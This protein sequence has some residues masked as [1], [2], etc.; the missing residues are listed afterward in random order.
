MKGK[1]SKKDMKKLGKSFPKRVVSLLLCFVLVALMFPA[2]ELHAHAGGWSEY[3]YDGYPYYVEWDDE[4]GKGTAYMEC[5]YC[6]HVME[7]TFSDNEHDDAAQMI[8]DA[9]WP[10]DCNHCKECKDDYHCRLC[11]SCPD[12]DGNMCECNTML[13]IDCHLDDYYCDICGSCRLYED[14][15]GEHFT[16]HHQLGFPNLD[17]I[18]GDCFE[19]SETCVA[20]SNVVSFAG[21]DY[22][23]ADEMG[24][25][26]CEEC[27][28][29]HTCVQNKDVAAAHGHCKDC[30][31]CGHEEFVC[32]DCGFCADCIDDR[33]NHCPLCDLCFGN[34]EYDRCVETGEHCV[35]CCSGEGWICE[36]CDKCTVGRGVEFC[37]NCGLCV[38]CC[39]ENS[40]EYGCT[41]GLCVKS[42]E[43][44]EHL[45]PECSLCPEDNECAYCGMCMECVESYHCEHDICPD[46]TTEWEEHLCENCENC[47]ELDELCE[48][49]HMCDSCW[50]HCEHG[51]CPEDDEYYDHICDNCGEC[52]DLNEFCE[53]CGLCP[54]CCEENTLDMDCEHELCVESPEFAD[55]YCFE[56]NRCLEFCHHV[57]DCEHENVGSS[58]KKN[59]AAHWREC[60]DCGGSADSSPHI[61][62]DPVIIRQ[63]DILT[64]TMGIAQVSCKVCG[65]KMD[66]IS[67]PYN[68]P[69]NDGSPY[70]LSQPKDYCG[71]VSVFSDDEEVG[72][73]CYA[74]FTVLAAGE[75][76]TY[77][78]YC[79]IDGGAAKKLT[80]EIGAEEYYEI[81]G[82]PEVQGSTKNRLIVLV[83]GT[84]CHRKYEYW[85]VVR[86]LKGSVTTRYAQMAS[87]HNFAGY[88]WVDENTHIRCC[89]GDGCTA[90]R[91]NAMEHR[92]TPWQVDYPATTTSKGQEHRMCR[93]CYYY[94][95]APIQIIEEGHVH[96][97]VKYG[98]NDEYHWK[99]CL[100]GKKTVASEHYY[101]E[102]WVVVKE[103]TEFSAGKR[104]RTCHTCFYDQY[105]TIEKLPHTHNFTSKKDSKKA[106]YEAPNGGWNDEYHYVNCSGKSCTSMHRE[107]HTY[108]AWNVMHLPFTDR[109]GD[110]HP[111][112][113][114]RN[115]SECG[116][117]Q[118]VEF[119]A[120]WPIATE[121]FNADSASGFGG[122][123]ITGPTSANAG[124][125]IMLTVELQEGFVPDLSAAPDNGWS[126]NEVTS[127]DGINIKDTFYPYQNQNGGTL[128]QTF[129]TDS[130]I[131]SATFT[132]PDGP[133]ALGFFVKECDHKGIRTHR[134]TIEATCTGYGATV[135]RCNKCNGIVKELSRTDPTGHH[136]TFN[137]W[138]QHGDCNTLDIYEQKCTYCGKTREHDD[139]YHHLWFDL[140]NAVDPS[141]YTPGHKTDLKCGVCG[142][143]YFG[144]TIKAI[145][146]H[147]WGEWVVT[148]EPTNKTKGEQYRE[149]K[150]CGTVQ[151]QIMDY[152]GDDYELKPDKKSICFD[153]I[154]GDEVEPQFITYTSTG[155]NEIKKITGADLTEFGQ[156]SAYTAEIVD[157]MTVRITPNMNS[158]WDYNGA[159]ETLVITGIDTDG[160]EFTAPSVY[161]TSNIRKSSEKYSLSIE[162]GGIAEWEKT[163]TTRR[164]ANMDVKAGNEVKISYKD[165][166]DFHHWE[167][168]EDESG[169]VKQQLEAQSGIYSNSNYIMIPQ[170]KVVLR[171]VTKSLREIR[172]DNILEPVIGCAPGY[173]AIKL[174]SGANY[175]VREYTWVC[176]DNGKRLTSSDQFESSKK[177]YAEFYI[178]PKDGY[179]FNESK[180]P[181][182]VYINGGTELI[183]PKW[184]K[185]YSQQDG[186][187]LVTT[188]D[189]GAL[190][191]RD[192]DNVEITVGKPKAGSALI[193]DATVT[194]VGAKL[195]NSR[196]RVS[197]YDITD[198]STSS[199]RL[200]SSAIAEEGHIYKVEVSL[201]SESG[202]R[203]VYGSNG[204]KVTVNGSEADSFTGSE[205][206]AKV[207]YTFVP[208]TKYE[209]WLG[210]VQVNAQNMSDI[211]NDGGK[212]R[213]NPITN[214][215]TLSDPVINGAYVSGSD[216]YKIYSSGI[217]LNVN[218]SYK[219]TSADAKYGISVRKGDLTLN[220]DFAFKGAYTGISCMDTLTVDGG[221]LY[222]EGEQRNG[223]ARPTEMIIGSGV[224]RVEAKG[225]NSAVYTSG[226]TVDPALSVTAPKNGVEKHGKVYEADGETLAKHVVFGPKQASYILGDVDGDGEATVIDATYV[227]R[228]ATRVKV[229]FTD[230]QMMNGD[231]DSDGDVTAVD[232]TFI[233]RYATKVKVPYKIG[234]PV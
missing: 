32:H 212:A 67:I 123:V 48:Y 227:Q 120:Q 122:A 108:H 167:V 57:E 211:L 129:K 222:A 156:D 38:D 153:F 165:R 26:W 230:E 99:Q 21:G 213:F 98:Y 188:N 69:T 73:L 162:G 121:V 90:T 3:D 71:K 225:S 192:I 170:N 214:T 61:P 119:N 44:E 199:Q 147:N 205:T 134:D 169:L 168:V 220:G 201:S 126:L 31:V 9:L 116:H 22:I 37:E 23:V 113:M 20:C 155:R 36:Q 104:M 221:S 206:S 66:K 97:W 30:G 34:D 164:S 5:E 189:I 51:L 161:I 64:R 208:D 159:E 204:T 17:A 124:S 63:P 234:E 118:Q 52:F 53:Y 173:S 200:S 157:D 181:V 25:E 55:H 223:I 78:W 186:W 87:V 133:I 180:S 82:K 233:Q 29:C 217:D 65:Y 11:G 41:H 72:K 117:C 178:K 33:D 88:Q 39:Y 166:D 194:G 185:P 89:L 4:W 91:G 81:S 127:S 42:S 114:Y 7:C 195:A 106:R 10:D 76:N 146:H 12:I 13:C 228:Y 144:E 198:S 50:E 190:N 140:E 107:K 16:G 135:D 226:L 138:I 145:G 174:P 62:G 110:Y 154:Y 163:Y 215:L 172:L 202:Y 109:K 27:G 70:I 142:E 40:E 45:C 231:A 93:D 19:D 1:N 149:C 152:E 28:L 229:P 196:L 46:N 101:P 177:Y 125:T 183:D 187:Y 92:F 191:S 14:S 219:M 56:D 139:G 15:T 148:K 60:Y 43:F 68:S 176:A 83:D 175:T 193:P 160:A 210:D 179:L 131:Y 158:V 218:G 209:L 85:C 128:R 6:D 112:V 137:R 59:A 58:W 94:E 103:P 95:I 232:A 151:T 216:T 141:C 84:S 224:L 75:N 86:N 8:A 47:F 184:T 74:A 130:T 35:Q 79:R 100:C 2:F 96:N 143:Y 54:D 182:S 105:E 18:C 111:G 136:W 80:D 102:D 197:W 49:C 115:C 132:M 203:F 150:R 77:Q 207:S 171:A 24:E